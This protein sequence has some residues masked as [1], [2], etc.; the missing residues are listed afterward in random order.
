MVLLRSL[1]LREELGNK[2]SAGLSPWVVA[3]GDVVKS[4]RSASSG[5]MNEVYPACE[6]EEVT[7]ISLLASVSGG[8]TGAVWKRPG[9]NCS[10]VVPG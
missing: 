8:E 10:M 7:D 1:S 6:Q 3:M 2:G 9:W 5:A 4:P